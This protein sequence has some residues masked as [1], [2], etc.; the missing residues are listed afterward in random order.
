MKAALSPRRGPGGLRGFLSKLGPGLVTGAAD[1]D[2]SGI[3]TYSVAGAQ[4]GFACLWTAWFSFLLMAATQLLCARLG[5]ITGRGLAGL[6]REFYGPRTLWAACILLAVANVVNIGADLG[7]MAASSSM[8]IGIPAYYLAPVY[9]ALMIWLMAGQAYRRIATVLKWMTLVLF[10]YVV[11]AFLAHPDWSSV[12]RATFVPH[13]EWSGAYLATLVAILGTTISPYLFF[14]Q[15]S[16]EV[17]EDRDHGKTTLAQRQGATEQEKRDSRSDVITGML[18]SNVVMYFIIL[19]TSTTLHAHGHTQIATPQEAAEALRP[20]AGKAAYLLFTLGIVGTGM[21]SVP[22]LAGSTAYAVAEGARWRN[23]LKYPPGRA[24]PFY[25]VLIVGLLLGLALDYV[26]FGVIAMLFWS[27]VINGV[28]APPLIVLIVLL[29]SDP[30]VMG[31]HVCSPLLRG[32]GWLTAAV[33]TFAAIAM[34][35]TLRT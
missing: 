5:M 34:F 25:A 10:A 30:A 23:S 17:E 7:A 19:T 12:L 33:M 16:Q 22:V 2:P 13:V 24:R 27:A 14:W 8:I 35:A 15:A 21:L 28:L 18:L 20:L 1:D 3:G 29:S 9:A 6:L 32:L 31:A 11:T 4:L 26:G